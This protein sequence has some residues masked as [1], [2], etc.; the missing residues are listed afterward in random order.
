ML[1]NNKQRILAPKGEHPSSGVYFIEFFIK[2]ILYYWFETLVLN[3]HDRK[4]VYFC[5]SIAVQIMAAYQICKRSNMQI[6]KIGHAKH[7]GNKIK[8]IYHF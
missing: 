7:K 3:G 1:M 6:A 2:T 5:E 8:N 4:L